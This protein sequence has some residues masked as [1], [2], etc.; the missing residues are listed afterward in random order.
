M[1]VLLLLP[2]VEAA[3]RLGFSLCAT[4]AKEASS[5]EAAAA[6][7]VFSVLDDILSFLE[8]PNATLLAQQPML[9][10]ACTQP[11]QLVSGVCGRIGR[12]AKLHVTICMPLPL[13]PP[14]CQTFALCLPLQ[15]QATGPCNGNA[16]GWSRSAPYCARR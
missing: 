12:R 15:G 1:A 4:D 13:V 8:R 7:C 2:Q 3:D 16:G 14:D 5:S 11:C 6:A 10:W 9:R